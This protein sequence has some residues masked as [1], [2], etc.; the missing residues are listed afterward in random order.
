MMMMLINGD[1]HND[2]HDGESDDNGYD[3]DNFKR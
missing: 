2:D 1:D 3:H